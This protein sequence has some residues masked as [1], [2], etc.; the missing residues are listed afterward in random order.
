MHMAERVKSAGH[1]LMVVQNSGLY[2]VRMYTSL[3]AITRGWSRIF[4]GTFCTMKRLSVSLA[5][6]SIMGML[7]YL[8]AALGAAAL[9]A[10]VTATAVR[11]C[12]AAAALA[13]LMQVSAIYRFYSLISARKFLAWTY[14]LG[15]AVGAICLVKAMFKL[16][17]GSKL[18]WRNTV[19]TKG[20]ATAGAAQES[21]RETTKV[22]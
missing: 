21:R 2:M 20:A 7:P 16:R 4:F 5:V 12:T 22:G 6:I 10:G 8:T 15:C 9:A 19:Y 14:V 3:Q 1:R 18:N 11:V 17:A 13:I